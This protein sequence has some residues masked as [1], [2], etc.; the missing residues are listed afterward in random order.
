MESKMVFIYVTP[1][2]FNQDT[3]MDNRFFT[4]RDNV[5][6]CEAVSM[7]DIAAK[8]GTPAYI[9]SASAIRAQ[10]KALQDAFSAALPDNRQPRFCF[11]CKANSNIHV[12]NV[13]REA[14]CD[15]E[16]VSEGEL[17]RGLKAGF[18]ANQIVSTGVGKTPSEITA[19]LNAGIHQ[20]NVESV[21]ELHAINKIAGDM[22]KIA[23]VVFRLNPNVAAGGDDKIMTGRTRDKFGIGPDRIFEAFEL[24]DEMQHIKPYGLSMHI[25]SQI[26]EVWHFRQAYGKLA[27]IVND[28]RSKGHEITRLD[29][30]GGFGISYQDETPLDP[31][32]IASAVKD[33]I[34]PLGTEIVMEP[35]RF[36]VGNCGVLLSEILYIKKTADK[37]F[38]IL[39]KAM[40][41]LLRPSLYDAYHG[42]APV[43]EPTSDQQQHSYDI[44][45]PICET[46]DTFARDRFL[47]EMKD[48]QL[49]AVG[50]AGAYGSCMASNYNTRPMLPEILVDGDKATLIR[51]RQ[52]YDDLLE[53]EAV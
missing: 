7:T 30:G 9:Y 19:S 47:P 15:L 27:E 53:M 29:I 41:D 52:T 26:H 11:A 39:D 31:K 10:V 33:L 49:V 25:G 1:L 8:F 50:S 23:P 34:E 28:L 14:G 36:L 21:E 35:G 2:N 4:Y 45:G 20:F 38:L 12:L 42:I 18:N 37:H 16:I 5:L 13:I 48:G 51:R 3:I 43:Q 44:V 17:V 40:N 24:A 22:G 6:H 32:E 46:G